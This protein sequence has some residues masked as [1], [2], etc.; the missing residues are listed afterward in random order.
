MQVYVVTC[1]KNGKQYVGFTSR[2]NRFD[3]HCYNASIGQAGAL[4][5]AIRKYGRECFEYRTLCR[6]TSAKAAKKLEVKYIAKLNTRAPLGYNLTDGGDGQVGAKLS[7]ETRQRMSLAHMKRQKD[8]ALRARTSKALKGR[9]KS[10]EHVANVAAA[11]LGRHLSAETRARVS[12]GLTGK[13]QSLATRQKRSEILKRIGHRPPTEAISRYWKGR[14][15]S[16][17]QRAKISR[18]LKGRSVPVRTRRVLL[19]WAR[20]PKS[21]AHRQAISVARK[22]W[23]AAQGSV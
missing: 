20:K 1:S 23:W 9:K 10:A 4:Y 5:N 2:S 18:T 12:V 11:L 21:T 7:Y 17:E 8:P 19:K 6:C 3:T 16:A 14:P 15:K 13:T 22:A